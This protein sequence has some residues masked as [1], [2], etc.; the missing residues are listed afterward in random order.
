MRAPSHSTAVAYLALFTALSGTAYA[1]TKIGSKE[2]KDNSIQSRD[3]KNRAIAL[4]DISTKARSS[5]KG[6]RGAQGAAGAP[7]APGGQGPAGPPGPSGVPADAAVVSA[8]GTAIENG[9]QLRA[10]LAALPT[11]TAAD[12]QAVVLGVGHFDAGTIAAGFTI[13]AYVTLAGQGPHTVVENRAANFASVLAL[14]T[15]SVVRDLSVVNP[16]TQVGARGI[17]GQ[18]VIDTLVE[19]VAVEAR[20]GVWLRAAT[21]R[22]V[23]VHATVEG[24]RLTAPPAIEEQF[25]IDNV[26]VDVRGEAA[27]VGVAA[28]GGGLMDGVDSYVQANPTATALRF[29]AAEGGLWVRNSL[30]RAIGAT[31][32]GVE[33]SPAATS[34]AVLHF[35]H[36]AARTFAG[37]G[38]G[39]R[40][41]AA[42]ARI[43]SSTLEGVTA[44]VSEVGT[45]NVRCIDTHDGGYVADVDC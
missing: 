31:A 9:A 5:L 24:L 32:T 2:I 19:R 36:S 3:I 28:A 22:D 43:G 44:D 12:P 41:T 1:A 17:D 8:T 4:T 14:G 18:T 7:G 10:A 35:D 27:A 38:Y 40:A 21:V 11:A 33:V 13:P 23:S 26:T 25:E 29:T 16:S 6:Q 39:F 15:R 34:D 20:S 37:T 30:F 42:T 45:S